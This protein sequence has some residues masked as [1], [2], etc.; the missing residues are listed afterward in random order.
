MLVAKALVLAAFAWL[1]AGLAVGIPFVLR[2][3]GQIDEAARN[4]SVGFRLV[5]LPG[6]AALWPVLLVRWMTT[7]EKG[8]HS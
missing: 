2:G 7:R 5:I 1:L 4:A 3:A 8:D 6:T